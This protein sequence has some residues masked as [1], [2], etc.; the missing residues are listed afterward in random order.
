MFDA[1]DSWVLLTFYTQPFLSL[2]LFLLVDAKYCLL[3]D[4]DNP[5]M[6]AVAAPLFDALTI[7]KEPS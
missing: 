1:L 2:I 7:S 3:S 6:D 4:N 5:K